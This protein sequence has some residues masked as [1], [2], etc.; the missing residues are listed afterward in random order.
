MHTSRSVPHTL[1]WLARKRTHPTGQVFESRIRDPA[2]PAEGRT[3]RN[4][5]GA[6]GGNQQGNGKERKRESAQN[7][8]SAKPNQG[9]NMDSS[10]NTAAGPGPKPAPGDVQSGFMIDAAPEP[11]ANESVLA[12]AN[13]ASSCAGT[14]DKHLCELLWQEFSTKWGDALRK[15]KPVNTW[16]GTP[17]P[18]S[19]E[20][21]P[22]DNAE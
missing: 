9:R 20:R 5:R 16:P 4:R 13:A 12:A 3:E 18:S 21:T 14:G 2:A 6:D 1:R 15:S 11:R 8:V 10:S 22:F 19:S 17:D 7:P